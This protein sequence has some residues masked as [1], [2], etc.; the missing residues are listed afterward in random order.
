MIEVAG[1]DDQAVIFGCHFR[2]A[3]RR[4]LASLGIGVKQEQFAALKRSWNPVE[5]VHP[6]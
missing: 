4:V 1:K 3:S 2:E 6:V 5:I